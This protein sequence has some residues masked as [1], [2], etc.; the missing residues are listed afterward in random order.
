[1]S[2]ISYL[3]FLKFTKSRF[4][5]III[6]MINQFKNLSCL[7]EIKQMEKYPF[8]IEDESVIKCEM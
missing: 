4:F 2:E 6:F 7:E 5:D 1:M 3:E 8:G